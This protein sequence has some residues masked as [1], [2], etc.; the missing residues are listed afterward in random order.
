MSFT[1]MVAWG[2]DGSTWALRYRNREDHYQTLDGEEICKV[3]EV[4]YRKYCN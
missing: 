1:D 3:L 2:F 4:F